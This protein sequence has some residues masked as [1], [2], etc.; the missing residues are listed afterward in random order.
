MTEF[1]LRVEDTQGTILEQSISN[2]KSYDD[3][4]LQDDLDLYVN[5]YINTFAIANFDKG[6]EVRKL[7]L[8]H[9]DGHIVRELIKD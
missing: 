5:E 6:V 3:F 4:T 8:I 2:E 9:S 7:Q 1:T